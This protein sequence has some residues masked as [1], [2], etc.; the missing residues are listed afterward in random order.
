MGETPM[1]K[2]IITG[3][4]AFVLSICLT[5]PVAASTTQFSPGWCT[6]YA[7][8]KFDAIVP[9]PGILWKGH[10]YKWCEAAAADGWIVVYNNICAA[11]LGAIAVY[12]GGPEGMGHVVFVESISSTGITVSEMNWKGLWI[13]STTTLTWEQAKKRPTKSPNPPLIFRGYIYPERTSPPLPPISITVATSRNQ[14][15]LSWIRPW[16]AAGF[17][18]ERKNVL[19]TWVQ[20]TKCNINTPSTTIDYLD[21]FL[22]PNTLYNYRVKAFFNYTGSPSSTVCARTNP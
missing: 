3:I 17:I 21:S 19:G 11:K 22:T 6:Y 10:A 9:P 7:A 18:V 20:L 15:R 5:I 1:F 8:Q 14:V 4:T 12:T 16:Y 2:K 13:I